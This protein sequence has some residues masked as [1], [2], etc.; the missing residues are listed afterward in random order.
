MSDEP[1]QV[2]TAQELADRCAAL[3]AGS[4]GMPFA[5]YGCGAA[6]THLSYTDRLLWVWTCSSS[7][8]EGSYYDIPLTEMKDHEAALVW[9]IHL[10]RTKVWFPASNY[11]WSVRLREL[12]RDLDR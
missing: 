4:H 1:G 10:M 5:C 8:C 3:P 6:P 12:F 2:L 7:D 9:T 11:S